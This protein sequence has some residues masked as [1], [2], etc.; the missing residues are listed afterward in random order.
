MNFQNS[1]KRLVVVCFAAAFLLVLAAPGARAATTLNLR[2]F[3]AT[4]DGI[5][6]DGPA[7]QSALDALAAA[8][9]GTLFVPAG[10]YVIATRVVKDF[11]GLASSVTIAGVESPT[12]APTT[13]MSGSEQSRGLDLQSEFRPKT[14]TQFTIGIVGLQNF[15]IHDIAFVGTPNVAIDSLTTLALNNIG[16][17]TVHHCEFYGLS[18]HTDGGS[19]V[20]ALRS[21]LRIEQSVFLGCAA[22]SGYYSPLVQNLQWKGIHVSNTTFLDYGQR[23]EIFSKMNFGAPFGWV[24]IG[25]AAPPTPDSPR[26]E[27]VFRDVFLDE[28][29][30]VGLASIPFRYQPPSAPIDL[31]YV[32]GLR[33]NVSN[34]KTT[35][36]YFDGPRAA[37]VER[38][39]YGWSHNAD[40][41]LR[42]LNAGRIIL[43]DIECVAHADRIQAESSVE[44]LHVINSTYTTLDSLAQ[45]TRVINTA[46]DDEDPVQHVRARYESLLARPPDAAG[47]FYWSD[48][49]LRCGDDAACITSA[50]AALA[51]YL[52]NAPVETFA[53]AGRVTNEGG[54]GVAGLAV[55]LTGSQVVTVTTDS[56]GHYR[57]SNLPTAGVYVVTPAPPVNKVLDPASTNV[58]T[59]ASDRTVNFTLRN[60]PVDVTGRVADTTGSPLAGVLLTLTGSQ[61]RTATTDADGR[62]IF[63]ALPHGGSYTVTPSKAHYTFA[64]ASRAL[65]NLTSDQTADFTATLNSYTIAGRVT[66]GGAG[67]AGLPVSLAG[68]QEAT[69][70]TDSDGRYSFRVPAL[71]DY[72]IAPDG[73]FSFAPHSRIYEDL[74]ANYADANFTAAIATNLAV[75]KAASQSSTTSGGVASR[76]TDGNTDGDWAHNSVT[77]TLRE[78][79]PWWQ[80]DLG[81]SAQ[82]DSI[83]VWNRTDCCADRLSNFYIIVSDVPFVS[84]D[85]AATLAQP[86]VSAFHVP[87]TGRSTQRVIFRTGR[88]VRIQLSGTNHLSLAEVEIVGQFIAPA[89]ASNLA[90]GRAATQASTGF[91]GSAARA[92]DGDTVGDWAHNSVSATLQEARPWW[93]VDLGA[94]RQLDT[95]RV[96]NRTD[97][98]ADR[99]SNFYVLVSDVPFASTDLTA[100]LAQPGV[101]AFHTSGQAGRP[102]TVNVNR[103]GRYVRVQLAGTNYLSLAEVEV[104]GRPLTQPVNV[105][106]GGA[107]TQSSTLAYSIPTAASNAVDGNTSGNFFVGS[108]AHTNSEAQAWWQVDL[109]AVRQVDSIKI[110]N[111]T[112]CCGERLSNFY[113]LF[114]DA[115]FTSQDLAAT[116]AQPGVTSYHVPG[117]VNISHGQLVN[118]TARYVRIQLAGTNYLGLAEVQVLG[119]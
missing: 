62:Y 46:T 96:W 100:T 82:I 20:G 66:Q 38:S 88:Y 58:T 15:L 35:G 59:P 44:S 84:N 85:L 112:D 77:A 72:F 12:P 37:M 5:T 99:L 93:Q 55:A 30:Y 75:G 32:T 106:L 1:L 23:A 119:Q 105:A 13:D 107:A 47:H 113:I 10:R 6:D 81:A 56:E 69:T 102:T 80:V 53:I 39:F 118:R 68:A 2:D 8:G 78:T 71:G 9:G 114:S 16:E 26:R 83:R 94:T 73:P 79:R 67:V 43:D 31:I 109:G 50:R 86:G 49:I 61:T 4:G 101:S 51:S 34:L 3:G 111:R 60:A 103:P 41:A 48:R 14:G 115:P 116:L 91:G 21:R 29:G 18:S 27:A 24:G 89:G 110:W 36:H 92:V 63:D 74:A 28:G 117:G 11:T 98:C 95:V 70:T 25:N 65:A 7:L 17:A 54:A 104:I 52:S 108:M 64:P 19:I 97:C 76:A 40:S 45:T 57:F 33:M 90:L 22:S 42:F 87:L